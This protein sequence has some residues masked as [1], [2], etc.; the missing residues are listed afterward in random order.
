MMAIER[1]NRLRTNRHHANGSMPRDKRGW[2]VAPAPDGR[3]TPDEHK[4]A[5]PH[6]WRGFWGALIAVLAIN[7]ILVLAIGPVG[8]PR[9]KVPFSPYF[10]QQLNDNHVK[11][12]SSK[13]KTIEGTW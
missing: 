1:L 7:W 10:L 9:T 13:N 12:I 8:T 3:G 2:R 6:R 4:P 11:S 5:P